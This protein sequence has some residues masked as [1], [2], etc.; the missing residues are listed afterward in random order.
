MSSVGIANL[1]AERIAPALAGQLGIGWL[2]HRFI[3]VQCIA[4][5]FLHGDGGEQAQQEGHAV[6]TL[7]CQRNRRET[8]TT[9]ENRS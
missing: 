6:K 9:R 5:I 8:K 2:R 3:R 1:P 7:F 4:C